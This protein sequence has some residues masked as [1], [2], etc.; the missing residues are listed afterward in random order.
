MVAVS[1]LIAVGWALRWCLLVLLGLLI[2][3]PFL[4]FPTDLSLRLHSDLSAPDWEDQFAGTARWLVRFRW[5]WAVMA[6]EL[7][8]EN[9]RLTRL[10]FRILGF[11]PDLR[12]LLRQPS[13]QARPARRTS[14]RK[15]R[16]RFGFDLGLLVAI[17]QECGRF[18]KR[19]MTA[20]GFRFQGEITY[21][22]AD[23]ALTG[24]VE[25]IRWAAGNPVPI[26]MQADFQRPC[27]VGWAL[28]EGR[29][30]G[31]QVIGAILRSFGNPVIRH[32]L[33]G[34]IRFRP[35]QYL[36]TRVILRGG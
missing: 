7:A 6:G 26:R 31:Y 34:Q 28:A 33:F 30:Y 13:R 19:I 17:L 3:L 11:R 5:G 21:G 16:K 4:F 9:L 10:E 1:V 12:P 20:M 2:L 35:L 36:V 25:A 27:L 18:M 29:L 23:P 14:K 8:G 24:W 32:R 15:R 22:F